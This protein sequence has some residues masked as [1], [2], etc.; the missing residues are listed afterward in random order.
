MSKSK[1][2]LEYNTLYKMLTSSDEEN[3]VLALSIMNEHDFKTNIMC[4][5]LL[6]KNTDVYLTL[7]EEHAPYVLKNIKSYTNSVASN[8]LTYKDIFNVSKFAKVDSDQLE[9]YLVEL[10]KFLMKTLKNQGYDYI[11]SIDIKLNI[12]QHEPNRE[13]SES[14]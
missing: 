5:F 2:K 14:C 13:L 10:N 4:N 1:K 12:K 11:E 9:L 6:Y 3:K 7:W 8:Y